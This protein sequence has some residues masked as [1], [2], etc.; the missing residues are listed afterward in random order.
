MYNHYD[1]KPLFVKSGSGS[2]RLLTKVGDHGMKMQI[3]KRE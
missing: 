3:V 2:I 1:I